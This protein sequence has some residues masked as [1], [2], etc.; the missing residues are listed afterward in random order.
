MTKL[1]DDERPLDQNNK[2]IAK[3]LLIFFGHPPRVKP[4]NR[5]V[6][7]KGLPIANGFSGPRRGSYHAVNRHL[8]GVTYCAHKCKH[9]YYRPVSK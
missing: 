3:L 5:L 7:Q 4:V 1:P 8:L 2:D 6:A 9:C